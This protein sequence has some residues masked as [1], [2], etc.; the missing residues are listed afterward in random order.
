VVL[1]QRDWDRWERARGASARTNGR[2]RVE[3]RDLG[4]W[5]SIVEGMQDVA[6]PGRALGPLLA[7]AAITVRRN[8]AD[9]SR[10]QHGHQHVE[11]GHYRGAAAAQRHRVRRKERKRERREA[12]E[13]RRLWPGSRSLALLLSLAFVSR[14]YSSLALR[15]SSAA[16]PLGRK[17]QPPYP[18]APRR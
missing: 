1:V 6:L 17:T 4:G 8:E 5:R 18:G 3:G 7:G 14:E 2:Q 16:A 9:T 15:Q 13:A 12:T 11:L 10:Q